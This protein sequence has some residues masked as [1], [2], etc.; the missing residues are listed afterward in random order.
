MP[1]IV[2]TV[3]VDPDANKPVEG[4]ADAVTA[5]LDRVCVQACREGL[6]Q[7]HRILGNF[8][9]PATLF[10]EARTL[11][12][13]THT[14]P[15]LIRS[16]C[17][18]E[19]YEH[20]CHGYRHEDLPGDVS[21]VPLHRSDLRAIVRQSKN[22]IAGVTGERPIGFRA[23]YCR[24]PDWA[25]AVIHRCGIE[26]DSSRTARLHFSGH[27][28]PIT[29]YVPENL[30]EGCQ[31]RELPLI[32]TID[33]NGDAISGYLWQLFEGNRSVE[34]YRHMVETI[35]QSGSSM[36][37]QLAIHPWHLSVNGDGQKL[38]AGVGAAQFTELI[39]MLHRD[40]SWQWGNLA[41][42]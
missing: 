1:D 24:L 3:D 16:I 4:R 34:D 28:P 11:R 39:H 12:L 40:N 18:C 14:A 19:R 35:A 9:L 32:S 8:N 17:Q 6:Y 5:G 33:Q 27:P 37:P 7:L 26:Y 15:E 21:G 36:P 41:S 42:C 20:A 23:P 29:P 13:L 38:P 31:L 10:W 25:F 2:L 30:P 22:I